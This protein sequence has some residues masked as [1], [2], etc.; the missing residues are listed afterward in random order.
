MLI[1]L[2]IIEAFAYILD[3]AIT[4]FLIVIFARVV[5]SWIRIPHNQITTMIYQVTE[6]ILSPLR[7]RLPVKFGLDFS[8]MI[9]FLILILLRMV[10]VG[11]LFDY[12]YFYRNQYL[13][14]N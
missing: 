1:L 7:R 6:P 9:I 12:A 3:Y 13:Q 4:F 10:V 2:R 14:G 11:S 5:L 8:P